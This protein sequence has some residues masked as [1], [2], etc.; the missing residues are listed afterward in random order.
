[1]LAGM[2]PLPRW[3]LVC[4]ADL[5]VHAGALAELRRVLEERPAWAMV[6]PR[7]HNEDGTVYPSVRQFPDITD[8]AGH[9][10]FALVN[11]ENR[12]TK[13]YNPGAPEGDVVA[14]AGW[15]SGSR[16][17]G[18][19]PAAPRSRRTPPRGWRPGGRQLRRR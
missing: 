4:N 13:R 1:M 7:I 8:A 9:A 6:G 18:S 3:V 12:F 17:G 15:I 10:L 19:S 2:S 5:R 16:A 14:E 11:P